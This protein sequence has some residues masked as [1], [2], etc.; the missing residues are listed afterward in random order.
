MR[1]DHLTTAAGAP[2][3]SWTAIHHE[4]AMLPN[5]KAGTVPVTDGKVLATIRHS[6]GWPA[7]IVLFFPIDFERVDQSR[8]RKR[9]R[10]QLL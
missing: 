10:Q 6:D 5:G 2:I 8:T 7:T 3:L 1:R 4:V 9:L